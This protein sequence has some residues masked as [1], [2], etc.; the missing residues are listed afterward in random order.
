[1]T[2]ATS[3]EIK[4]PKDSL[5]EAGTDGLLGEVDLN[6]DTSRASGPP[7]EDYGYLKGK[8]REPIPPLSDQ[9]RAAELLLKLAQASK[10]E[11]EAPKESMPSPPSNH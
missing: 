10:E 4:I 2:I 8:S 3:Y 7:I 5:A 6:I 11:K 9:V 1:M